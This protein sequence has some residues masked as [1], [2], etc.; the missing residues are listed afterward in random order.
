[1]AGKVVDVNA[2]RRASYGTF[3]W[4]YTER[5]VMLYALSLGCRWDEARYVYE[6]AEEFAALPTFGVIPPYHDL[7]PSLPL[8]KIVPKFNPVRCLLYC[9]NM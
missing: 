8:D 9:I 7:L 5:D 6:N 4:R 2:V 1:M 3:T